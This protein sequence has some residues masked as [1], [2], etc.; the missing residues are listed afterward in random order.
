MPETRLSALD[1]VQEAPV[2][3]PASA[4]EATPAGKMAWKHGFQVRR[5]RLQEGAAIPDHRRSEEEVVFVHEGQLQVSLGGQSRQLG[6][7]DLVTAPVDM[8]RSYVND[9]TGACDLVVVRGG[10]SPA[11]PQW[12]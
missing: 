9:G 2:L 8:V 11:A 5:L 4:A 3:G 10:D 6:P 7:G 12:V 1:G